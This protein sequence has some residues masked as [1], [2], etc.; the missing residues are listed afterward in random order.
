MCSS[1]WALVASIGF[2]L[3]WLM[4]GPFFSFDADKWQLPGNNVM[5]VGSWIIGFAILVSTATHAKALMTK[6][7]E[8]IRVTDARNELIDI[9]DDDVENVELIHDELKKEKS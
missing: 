2:V 1:P 5:T 9:E 3:A 6:L 4:I 8:L 7:D